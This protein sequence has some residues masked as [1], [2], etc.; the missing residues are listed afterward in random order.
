MT[1]RKK[2][3]Q[4]LDRVQKTLEQ[5]TAKAGESANEY[6]RCES[7]QDVLDVLGIENATT[8]DAAIAAV[9][10]DLTYVSEDARSADLCAL[11][12]AQ[13]HIANDG[14]AYVSSDD[15]GFYCSRVRG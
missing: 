2:E 5:L 13:R 8:L 14:Y 12:R 10:A 7:E 4:A 11:L 15:D 1:S 9:R 3:L 6:A